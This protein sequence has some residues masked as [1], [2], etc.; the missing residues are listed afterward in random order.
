M[1]EMKALARVGRWGV[2]GMMGVGGEGVVVGR[3][4][5]RYEVVE[6]S[7]VRRDNI[8]SRCPSRR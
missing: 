1:M 3:V 8:F 7:L 4:Y 6:V 2:R 5:G